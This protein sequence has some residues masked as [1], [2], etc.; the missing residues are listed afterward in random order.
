MNT[1]DR[2]NSI[3]IQTRAR[4]LLY[5]LV[6]FAI[7]LAFG[8]VFV[9][10]IEERRVGE[11]RRDVSTIGSGMAF[12]VERALDRSLASTYALA[13]V[14]RERES[15]VW[16][17]F[18]L[19]AA[20]M[21]ETF[22]GVDSLQ[23]AP[24][25]VVSKIYPL[26]GKEAAIGHDLLNDPARRAEA[27]AAIESRQ[28]T[29][30]GPFTLV[31]G[32]IA[33]I[34]RLPVF[35]PDD[36]GEEHFWGFTIA[37]IRMPTLLDAAMLHRTDVQKYDF[38]LSRVHP[39]TG[40]PDTFFISSDRELSDE[41]AFAIP[42]P[43]GNW[44]L[45]LES[46]LGR[47]PWLLAAQVVPAI[48]I[49][50]LLAIVFYIYLLRA[51][52]RSRAEKALQESEERYRRLVELSPDAIVVVSEGKIVFANPAEAT[53]M[54]ASSA[55]ELIG[56][57]PIGLLHPEDRTAV[58]ERLRRIDGTGEAS[59]VNEG[60]IVR[61]DGKV[62]DIEA[63]GAPITYQ[64]KK[65][66]QIIIRDITARKRLEEAQQ[67][68]TE[69]TSVMADMGRTVS[70]SLDI[71]D[72]Y[73][74][75]GHEIR[76]LIPFDRMLI[77]MVDP[78]GESVSHAFVLGTEGPGRQQIPLAG[79]FAEEVIRRRMAVMLEADKEADLRKRF[80][81]L[82]SPFRDGMRSFLAAPL[83]SRDNVIG[84]L[85]VRSKERG[86]YSQLHLDLAG[87]VANQIAGAVANSQLYA[88]RKQARQ[89]LRESEERYRRLV[90]LSP[91]AIAVVSK[92]KILFA[93]PAEATIMGASN[94]EELIGKSTI[95]ILH[96]EG[97]TT[98]EERI[99]R[100]N[101]KGE[102]RHVNEGKIN[103]LDGQVI[104]VESV[105]ASIIYQGKKAVQI[106]SRDVT[107]R[108]RAEEAERR[109][110]DETSTVAV[111]G[112]IVSSSLDISEVYDRLSEEVRKLVPFDR[113]SLSIV[114]H[115]KETTSPTWEFGTEI[116]GKHP[117][118]EVPL[119]GALAGEAVR[120]K[121]PIML[122]A[123]T[124]AD[125]VHRFPLLIP[126][127]RAGFRSFLAVPLIYRD[128][129]IGV[130]RLASKNRGIYTRRH[131]ELLDRIGSQIAG[132][133]ANVQ[134]FQRTQ[135]L[136]VVEE[137]NRL[138]VEIHDT[139]AQ[140][141]TGIVL[142][143]EAAEEA[144]DADPQEASD[145]LRRAKD[146]ARE[147]LQRARRS[148]WDLVPRALEERSLPDALEE[149]ARKFTAAGRERAAFSISGSKRDL[150][151][152][153]QTALLRI[154][155]ESLNN[156]RRHAGASE[157]QVV[158]GFDSDAVR[159]GVSDDGVGF[160]P[161]VLRSS[162]ERRGFG[163]F[164]MEQRAR[165]LGGSLEVTSRKGE[166]TRIEVLVPTT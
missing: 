144:L 1:L 117:G 36:S 44:T 159:L 19:I 164:G 165:L 35:V 43:N 160:D 22:G 122:E 83:I 31:Q 109:W 46:D 15:V 17:N 68:W 157:V 102:Y 88:E 129:V 150:P 10:L 110:A 149:E 85:Q 24:G 145:H 49:A 126:A 111:I 133:I 47:A 52:E 118:D 27:L 166:G 41:M 79:T 76:K 72:I 151:A 127:F 103:R 54:G 26:E 60:K 42:V 155:Q 125:L 7:V 25:G 39:D 20:S 77:S 55:E 73:E 45:H 82:L 154:C 81:G 114:D 6:L 89:A 92:G 96:G 32:G 40:Q 141:F 67:R 48:L 38:K 108:K 28:L 139:L 156:V 147:S 65:S 75:L 131:L 71:H 123:Q 87:R 107:Q 105:G 115:E 134:L 30:A 13:S 51:D 95:G 148:V 34:G 98:L 57:S 161:N 97:R 59:H 5:P 128:T 3:G 84:V 29:L 121:S 140:G 74:Q 8:L 56:K 100:I 18:D 119:A 33:T 162:G 94:P 62:R 80:P 135:D 130:L 90:E 37:L 132:A 158:L 86:V 58:E 152:R 137:R 63:A 21:I 53:L 16:D 146:L 124:E 64:G 120:T 138:A 14:V 142:Q 66:V 50:T 70:A 4:V 9:Q 69:E 163:L 116:P 2:L 143:L 93:N 99:L 23:L 106:V 11:K 91:D 112:R 113:F 153:V 104:D 12:E 78:E 101:E 136:A 61:L